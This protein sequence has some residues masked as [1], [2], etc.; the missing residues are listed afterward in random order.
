VS[1]RDDGGGRREPSIFGDLVVSL[2]RLFAELGVWL[3]LAMLVAAVI[4]YCVGSA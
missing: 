4:A 1:T 3:L 2:I